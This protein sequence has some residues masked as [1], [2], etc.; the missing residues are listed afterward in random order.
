MAKNKLKK[1]A[2][3]ESYNHVIQPSLEEL[4]SKFK[5]KGK[6]NSDF[7]K[8][9]GPIVLE[10]GCGKGEYSI[11]LAKEFPEKNFIGVDIKGAR[12]WSGAKQAIEEDLKNVFQ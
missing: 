7:F 2:E 9:K 11:S 8:N 1:F 6:W 5:Y 12:M 4:N 10:L 3:L